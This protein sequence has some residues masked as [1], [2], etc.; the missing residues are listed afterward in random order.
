MTDLDF[1]PHFSACWVIVVVS[2]I[3]DVAYLPLNITESKLW[4]VALAMPPTD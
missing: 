3:L 4:L 1:F 2:L